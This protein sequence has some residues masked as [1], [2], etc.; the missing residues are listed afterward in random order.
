M[1]KKILSS[2]ILAG[3]FTMA[4]GCD[5]TTKNKA[6]DAVQQAKENAEQVKDAGEKRQLN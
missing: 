2:L 4:A 6:D 1:N 5:D 3:V